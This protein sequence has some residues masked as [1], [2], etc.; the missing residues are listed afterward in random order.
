M[1]MSKTLYVPNRNEWRRWLERNHDTEKEVWLIY[2]KKYTG[3]PGIPYDDAVEEALSYG[4]ID[5][6]I[7][8]IDDETFCRKFTPRKDTS[9]WSELNK[10]RVEKLIMEGQMT[11]A[12]LAKI[13]AAKRTGKWKK[14]VTSRQEFKIP[15]E[16][17]EALATNKEAGK[18]FDKLAPSYQRQYV[19]W[20]ASAKKV[21][22]RKKRVKE[23]I[24]LLEQNRKLGMK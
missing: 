10:K 11:E 12:G 7:K 18:N 14:P 21:E 8:R 19:G 22:T 1:N 16:L 6:I 9:Q 4:W 24:E 15:P 17:I 3:K 13:E 2:Y 20:V 5:S 23:A